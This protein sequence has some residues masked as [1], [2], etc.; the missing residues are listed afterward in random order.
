MEHL[1]SRSCVRSVWIS[2][3]SALAVVAL[4]ACQSVKTRTF[5]A[6]RAGAENA[7]RI[8]LSQERPTS[9]DLVLKGESAPA[10]ATRWSIA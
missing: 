3:L 8:A 10:P 7:I 9:I 1:Q 4:A 6:D 5:G 2:L